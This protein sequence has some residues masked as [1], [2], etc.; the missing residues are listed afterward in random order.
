MQQVCHE[1]LFLPSNYPENVKSYKNF[2]EKFEKSEK[3]DEIMRFCCLS[4]TKVRDIERKVWNAGGYFW[5][6]WSARPPAM[7]PKSIPVSSRQNSPGAA[8]AA[9]HTDTHAKRG[10]DSG[11]FDAIQRHC[12]TAIVTQTV[13]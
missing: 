9:T 11:R 13:N 5:A 4:A 12:D 7:L 10:R 6:G 8:Q 1:A 2:T 3:F